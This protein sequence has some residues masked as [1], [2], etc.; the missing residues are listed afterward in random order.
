M[1]LLKWF[2]KIKNRTEKLILDDN[3]RKKLMFEYIY[4]LMGILCAV[5]SIINIFTKQWGLLIATG[6]F[7]VICLISILLSRILENGSKISST[8][9][10]VAL[11][12]MF[13][14]FAVSGG[15]EGFSIHW[16]ILLP[17]GSIL[18]YGVKIGSRMSIVQLLLVLLFF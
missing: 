9:I 17:L 4:W 2:K 14:Y 10:S 15:I 13:S 3:Q 1:R 6:S 12:I 7:V 5:M 18:L 16:L 11:I 8:I